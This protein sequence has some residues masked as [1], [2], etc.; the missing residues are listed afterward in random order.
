[1]RKTQIRYYNNS[2][3]IAFALLIIIGVIVSVIAVTSEGYHGGAD[4]LG[5]YLIS[6]YAISRPLLLLDLWGRPVFTIFGIPFAMLGFTAMK[7]YT[8]L[9]GLLT[10]WLA[11]L[12]IKKSGYSQPWMVIPMVL[13]A[14]VYFLLM[15]SPLTETI[16]GLMLIAAIWAFFDE[17]YVLSALLISFIP[18]ARFEAFVFFL[19]F[20]IAFLIR[21]KYYHLLLLPAG[22]LVFS[23]IGYFVFGDFLWIINKNPYKSGA[24]A[25]YGKGELLHY[26]NNWPLIQGGPLGI[27]FILGVIVLTLNFILFFRK[28]KLRS[29]ESLM[30][31]LVLGSTLTYYVAHSYSWYTGKG[32]S[33]GL[34]RMM[35]AVMP[36]A[37]IV[38]FI[39]F[40]FAA[41]RLNKI[42]IPV[43][44][45]ALAAIVLIIRSNL[46]YSYPIKPDETEKLM[47]KTALWLKEKKLLSKK[48]YYYD[49]FLGVELNRNP[50]G[51][52]NGSMMI[53]FNY[54][55]P[56]QIPE[57]GLL[58][59]DAHL[60]AN[61]GGIPLQSLINNPSF[62]LL[63]VEKPT[64][65]FTTLG[66]LPYEI[67]IFNRTQA[68]DSN[69]VDNQIRYQYFTALDTTGYVLLKEL[70]FE[71]G[72]PE[73]KGWITDSVAFE[74][75][76]SI[77]LD[78]TIE[79]LGI[80]NSSIEKLAGYSEEAG[81]NHHL[82]V[83]VWIKPLTQN[84]SDA[85]SLV[86][87]AGKTE[88][89]YF[90]ISSAQAK[91]E[92]NGWRYIEIN[93]PLDQFAPNET[94]KVYLWCHPG[95][96]AFAD[97]FKI[98]YSK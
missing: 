16:M 92:K 24:T 34:I 27:L 75:S 30:L 46:I 88:A 5:H 19:P 35:A 72:P 59:W 62:Q 8:I 25:I 91:I 55:N 68:N 37:S 45:T 57:G 31:I 70:T 61:E 58:V 49:I 98:K 54:L 66:N 47:K 43:I 15:I 7:F 53:H 28:E 73:L 94:V 29:K 13:L 90:S 40:E 84:D 48:L 3:I 65:P 50:F 38:S 6:R 79:Y 71:D 21:K 41:V 20:I 76:S 2:T 95:K 56:D 93:T 78:K 39:G 81:N 1:M 77:R 97:C 42:R 52:A 69:I 67:C 89:G 86:I 64:I 9:A 26:I 18:F 33:L 82:F 11:F 80:Y 87:N 83:S 4:T 96:K 74:G 12:L 17:R 51:D 60:G 14:P 63:H 36:T 22:F 85:V 10:A 32:N 23:I 44:I